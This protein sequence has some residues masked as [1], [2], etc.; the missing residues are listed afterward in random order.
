MFALTTEQW[1][2]NHGRAPAKTIGRTTTPHTCNWWAYLNTIMKQQQL[3]CL[4]LAMLFYGV[5]H[6]LGQPKLFVG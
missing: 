4:V 2:R 5:R 3:F 6:L 1:Q